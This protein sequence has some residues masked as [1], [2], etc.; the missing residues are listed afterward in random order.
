MYEQ[1]IKHIYEKQRE[2]SKSP[3]IVQKIELFKVP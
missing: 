3:T 1:L 2:L